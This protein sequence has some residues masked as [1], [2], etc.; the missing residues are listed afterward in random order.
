MTRLLSLAVANEPC[1]ADAV[2]WT[3]AEPERPARLLIVDDIADNRMILARRFA[4]RGFVIV[5]AD[6]GER[7]LELIDEQ[8]FDAVLLD[9]MMPG[10]GGLGVLKA[11]RRSRSPLDLPIIMVTAKA[12][13]ENV[14]EALQLQAN[15]YVTKPVNFDV[16]LARVTAQVDRKRANEQLR[17]ANAALKAI[18]DDLESRV[19]ERTRNLVA[20]NKALHDEIDQRQKSE[21]QTRFLARHDPLTGLP[22]RRQFRDELVSGIACSSTDGTT[23]VAVLFVDLDGFKD[24]NDALG[25]SI[26]DLLLQQVATEFT[27]ILGRSDRIARLGGDEFAILRVGS[28]GPAATLALA[29]QLIAIAARG[30]HILEQ[31]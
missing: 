15:D 23:P 27:A 2:R 31:M 16:A 8:P 13:A 4:R 9:V 7:A 28:D 20:M 22:N 3:A 21:A 25:H 17:S 14:V 12:E 1:D 11:V 10:I 18:N 6:S 29:A 19:E 5:E 30:R 24:V 26:G